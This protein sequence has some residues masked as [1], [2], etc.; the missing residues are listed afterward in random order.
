MRV[1]TLNGNLSEAKIIKS[2]GLERHDKT[3]PVMDE[4]GRRFC[5]KVHEDYFEDDTVG[6]AA[7]VRLDEEDEDLNPDLWIYLTNFVLQRN[8]AEDDGVDAAIINTVGGVLDN[9]SD[10]LYSI[11]INPDNMFKAELFE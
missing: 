4:K 1:C 8:W 7:V 9:V 2:R 10:K 3:A 5:L 6:V 11:F